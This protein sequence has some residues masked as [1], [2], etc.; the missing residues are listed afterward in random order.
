MA[1]PK[2]YLKYPKRKKGMDH[3]LYPYSN[4]FERTPVAWPKNKNV[5]LWVTV[6][7]EYFPLTSN[8][9]TPFKAPG[10]MVTPY[11]DYRTYTAREYG[12]RVGIYRILKAFDKLG[13]KASF[14]TN[15]A[16]AKRYPFLIEEIAKRGHEF[17]GHGTDM[18]ALHWGGM[19]I[20]VEHKQIKSALDGLRKATGQDVSG[21]LSPARSESQNTLALLAEQGIE[22]ACDWVNDDMP[23]MIGEG[24]KLIAMPHTM[25]L[26]DHQLLVNLGQNE[27]TWQEQILTAFDLLHR[28]SKIHGGRI[29]HISLTP[30][31]IGQAW[32]IKALRDTLEILIETGW[33][34]NATGAEIAAEW[35]SQ[36]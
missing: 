17:I 21:W 26:D 10:N 1:L 15:A 11:P 31:V 4:M 33:V 20:D 7:L 34:W 6:A 23:Y 12:N 9:E 35:R 30:Y 3:D 16:L 19:D 29:L 36:Q 24:E 25:E 13:I 32:R 14:P 22:Y 5:A 18:N 28:E 2:S 8:N 27:K